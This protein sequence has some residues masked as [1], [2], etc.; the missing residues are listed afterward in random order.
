[1]ADKT[2]LKDML[3]DLI[4]D[5]HEQAEMNAH[6]YLVAKMRDLSN[7]AP[8]TTEDDTEIEDIESTD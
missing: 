5:R 1:M 7:G 6:E 2:K 3:Q 8:V 4:N